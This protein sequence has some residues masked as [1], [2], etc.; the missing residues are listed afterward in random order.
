[1]RILKALL[2]QGRVDLD[3]RYYKAHASIP[4]PVD[5]PVMAAALRERSYRLCGA[6]AD[7][8]I[9]W[10][11]PGKYLRDVALPAMES[12]ARQAGRPVPPLI[13]HAPVAVHDN[14]AEVRQAVREQAATYPRS[15]FYVE[16]FKAAGFPEAEKGTWSN[17]MIDG[18]TLYGNEDQVARKLKE[19]L[20]YGVTEIIAS[21]MLAGKDREAS[22]ERTARLLAE[23]GG[24]AR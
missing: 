8:A 16:M 18:T 17:G 9:S 21:P 19:W 11:C 5:T 4:T 20:A 3:G 23:V 6:E 2:Q 15:P 13:A 12:G 10:V 24:S 1:L 22:W 14:T 7:G